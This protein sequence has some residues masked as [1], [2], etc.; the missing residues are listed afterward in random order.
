[1]VRGIRGATTVKKNKTEDIISATVELLKKMEKVNEYT[2]DEISHVI[3]TMTQDLNATFPARALRDLEGYNLVPVMCAQE[4]PV[5]DS[6]PNCIRIII[7]VNTQKS[8]EEIQHVYLKNAK[9]LRPDLS[10]A[11]KADIR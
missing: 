4:I 9:N 6:L 7:T 10:L 11:N 8:P 1:M 3:I 5:P 2:P